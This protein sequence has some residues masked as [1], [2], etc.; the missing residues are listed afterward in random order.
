MICLVLLSINLIMAPTNTLNPNGSTDFSQFNVVP[1]ALAHWDAVSEASENTTDYVWTTTANITELYEMQDIEIPNDAV[2]NNLTIYMRARR[3]STNSYRNISLMIQSS[4]VNSTGTFYTLATSY[5]TYNYTWST[6]PATNQPWNSSAINSIKIGLKS[7]AIIPGGQVDWVYAKVDYTNEKIIDGYKIAKYIINGSTFNLTSK[8]ETSCSWGDNK[9]SWKNCSS[10]LEIDNDVKNFSILKS[11]ILQ[12]I[13]IPRQN[14]QVYNS[15]LFDEYNESFYIEVNRTT[16]LTCMNDGDCHDWNESTRDKCIGANLTYGNCTY[17]YQVLDHITPR[18]AFRNFT[19]IDT[20]NINISKGVSAIKYTYDVPKYSPGRY[21]FSLTLDSLVYTLDP[22]VS[23]CGVLDT[24]GSIYTL[25]QSVTADGSCF[26]ITADDIT[27]DC[28]GF[29]IN[30]GLLGGTGN[31]YGVYTNAARTTIKNCNLYQRATNPSVFG[32]YEAGGTGTITNNTFKMKGDFGDDTTIAIYLG[33]NSNNLRNNTINGTSDGYLRYPISFPYGSSYNNVTNSTFYL[34][35]SYDVP[36]YL[37]YATQYNNIN[38]SN[39]YL[40]GGY[41]SMGVATILGANNNLTNIYVLDN[42]GSNTYFYF[43]WGAGNNIIKDVFINCTES[44]SALF[45]SFGEGDYNHFINVT[46]INVAN[47]GFNYGGYGIKRYWYADT[48]VNDTSGN[49]LNA[50]NVS[51]YNNVPTL[52]NTQ[53]TNTSGYTPLRQTLMEYMENQTARYDETNYSFNGT[54]TGY[55]NNAVAV[56][57]TGNRL[58]GT[59]PVVLTLTAS[60]GDTCTYGG[61]GNW[62]I[63]CADNCVFTT[64]QTIGTTNNIYVYGSGTL[65]FNNNGYW[66]FS[67]TN[68]FIA[69]NSGCQFVINSGGGII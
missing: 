48:Y 55:T 38:I 41:N 49:P 43:A 31:V 39:I 60:G 53:L 52:I 45:N 26:N 16:N 27:L 8:M 20:V 40:L 57:L 62:A 22:T 15:S 28:A 66:L 18:R 37:S 9:S 4:G 51:I 34:Y 13:D 17:F 68:Q 44:D 63:N 47:G 69:L 7:G 11:K 35:K 32:I 61:S 30:F 29:N 54:L 64:T 42:V 50:T 56:N 24:I 21:N 58:A 67:G 2:I 10:I 46:A 65:R 5:T 12:G 25:N 19:I 36:F 59:N 3:N 33:S 23:A 1:S 6:D 14:L